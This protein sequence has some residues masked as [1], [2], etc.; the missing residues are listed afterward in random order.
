MSIISKIL[1]A[2]DFSESAHHAFEYAIA[3]AREHAAPLVI[4]HAYLAPVMPALEGAIAVPAM[5]DA[6]AQVN[7]TLERLQ[8]HA[9]DRGVRQIEVIAREGV[10]WQTIVAVARETGCD[11]IV[12]GTH[13][14]SGVAH[15]LLGSVAEK[16]IRKAHCPV[17]A[18]K[19]PAAVAIVTA[20]GS[21]PVD[22][23]C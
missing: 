22:D 23:V 18:V 7:A 19:S 8:V 17:T 21:T 14:H 12:M 1:V 20:P 10:A 5:A 15:L 9:R 2:V 11:L 3:L 4:H 13:G 6:K 16:V